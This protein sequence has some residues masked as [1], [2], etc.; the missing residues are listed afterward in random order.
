MVL[1]WV[2]TFAQA[3]FTAGNIYTFISLVS[4]AVSVTYGACPVPYCTAARRTTRTAQHAAATPKR[5]QQVAVN[6][7]PT[8]WLC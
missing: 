4:I 7:L 3:A 8:S 1:T 5:V 6:Y 2:L